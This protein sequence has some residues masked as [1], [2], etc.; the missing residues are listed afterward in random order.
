MNSVYPL[1]DKAQKIVKEHTRQ[2]GPFC[3]A[4]PL[5][6]DTYM[7]KLEKEK[8]IDGRLEEIAKEFPIVNIDS[9]QGWVYDCLDIVTAKT[10]SYLSFWEHLGHVRALN[11]KVNS[12]IQECKSELVRQAILLGGTA[13]VAADIDY[14]NYSCNH[15]EMLIVSITGT[16]VRLKNITEVLSKEKH[17]TQEIGELSRAKQLLADELFI[18]RQQLFV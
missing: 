17:V 18:L 4:C 16:A 5:A 7:E 10:V 14:T 13:V 15:G 2:V 9:P 8:K 1:D 12:S 11:D 6:S 3:S